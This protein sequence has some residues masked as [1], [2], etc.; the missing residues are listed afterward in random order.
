MDCREARKSLMAFVDDELD[1]TVS[2]EVDRHLAACAGCRAEAESIRAYDRRVRA[3]CRGGAAGS[4]EVRA[5]L[6]GMLAAAVAREGRRSS[7]RRFA[8]RLGAVAAAIV[9]AMSFAIGL[10]PSP[11][12]AEFVSHHGRCLER[13]KNWTSDRD[14]LHNICLAHTDNGVL[15]CLKE[16]GYHLEKG[17]LCR[18]TGEPYLHLVYTGE[19]K[20]PVSV[21][22]GR[23][24]AGLAGRLRPFEHSDMEGAF[25]VMK[26]RCPHGNEY[27]IVA[28]PAEK[29]E[30]CALVEPQIGR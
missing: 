8:R 12:S 29:D 26:L 25:E 20:R 5:R 6:A 4:A 15:P 16:A 24:L 10:W 23:R 19:G 18:V 3:A 14:E 2:Y 21:F 1:A 11:A 17:K 7:L 22:I 27:V 13:G 9:V 28:A 30:I